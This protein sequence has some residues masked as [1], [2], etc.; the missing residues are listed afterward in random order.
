MEGNPYQVTSPHIVGNKKLRAPQK[1]AF[2]HLLEFAGE[3]AAEREVGIVLPVGC[4]KS[5]C[6]TIAPFAFKAKRTL[7]VAPGLNIATQ[8]QNDFDP[9]KPAMFY[10]KC[11][12]LDGAPYPEPV[13]IRGTTTNRGDLDEADVVITNIHQL[14]GAENKWLNSLPK[15]YFDLILF[16]EGHHSIAATWDTLKKRFPQA[17]IVNFSATPLRADGQMMAGRILYSYPIFRAIQEGYV[18]RL[19]AVQLNP[20]TLRYVRRKDDTEIEVSLDEV[21]RLGETDADFRK[22]IVTSKE[23]LETIVDVSIRELE[24]LRKE[25]KEK[26]IKIIASALNF[27]HCGQ[28]VE[29]YRAR[30]CKAD[31]V[32]S[33]SDGKA[34]EK[35]MR[36]LDNHE[37]DVIVQVRKL[38]EGFDHPFLAV[39]AVF[40]IFSNLSPF[41]QFVG[42]IMRVIKQNAPG[43]ILN[44]GVVVFHAGANIAS[45]W[46]DF[47]AYSEADQDYF[48]QLLPLEGIDPADKV[49]ERESEP[50][51]RDHSDGVEVRAQSDVGLEEIHL[52]QDEAAMAAL[53][54][55]KERGYSPEDISAAY[56]TLQPVP[57]TKALKRQAARSA[58]ETRV[59]NEVGKILG[60]REINPS[61]KELDKKFLGKTNFVV[62]KAAIDKQINKAVGKKSRERHD[63]TA[64]QLEEIKTKFDSIVAEAVTEVFGGSA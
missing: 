63:F 18:K 58:L 51:P 33:R 53:R 28:I 62:M 37:L 19:K 54:V 24:R 30:G 55:L 20:R 49:S 57:T 3:D 32:H 22:S 5:G 12:V 26:R 11:K 2:Q 56:G 46:T 40:S 38:G 44:Q 21:R 23:T 27:E 10:I 52:L 59:Q 42:R 50:V 16:D 64:Q 36:K 13:E 8:L 29:A 4:G 47:Q 60:K 43:H 48:D 9:T 34:N 35:V 14:Q 7:V 31:F 39:A 6:I 1:E 15:D 45:K 25:T 41:V 61:G 17:K